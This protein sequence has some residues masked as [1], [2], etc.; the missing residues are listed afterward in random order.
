M[1]QKFARSSFVVFVL[2]LFTGA[3]LAAVEA[4]MGVTYSPTPA[5]YQTK[6]CPDPVTQPTAG[7][8][9]DFTADTYENLWGSTGRNDLKTIADA[10][11]NAIRLYDWNPNESH[12]KFLDACQANGIKVMVPVSNWFLV[13]YVNST[14]TGTANIKAILNSITFSGTIHPAVGWI[15]IG[16]E[17]DLTQPGLG[18]DG[19]KTAVAAAKVV[20]AAG[21]LSDQVK[22]AFPTSTSGAGINTVLPYFKANL[23]SKT[24]QNHYVAAVNSFEVA[25]QK[26]WPSEGPA[27]LNSTLPGKLAADV[28]FTEASFNTQA[29]SQYACASKDGK[30]A[31]T[32]QCPVNADYYQCQCIQDAAMAADV[33]NA[34]K[35]YGK[36]PGFVGFFFFNYLYEPWKGNDGYT[37]AAHDV[38]T[39]TKGYDEICARPAWGGVSAIIGQYKN[40][41]PLTEPACSLNGASP[42]KPVSA[43][44]ASAPFCPGAVHGCAGNQCCFA[45]AGV[46]DKQLQGALNYACGAGADCKPL[47]S[48]GAC[49]SLGLRDKANFAMNNYWQKNKATGSCD[50][51]GVAE[52]VSCDTSPVKPPC[53]GCPP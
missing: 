25:D 33:L 18:S 35:N 29:G 13:T 22:L 9:T 27:S 20:I 44:Q 1:S 19:Y 52:T 28:V 51:G 6:P 11:F 42:D 10:G 46:T 15:G 14:T 30:L 48:G 37:F 53:R 23:P 43:C 32:S 47:N 31:P 4:V 16:N 45:K 21:V 8:C 7:G 41:Q 2:V 36:G 3:P 38:A 26:T 40:S 34:V 5:S 50:F 39:G 17:L 12:K 24:Y 49:E